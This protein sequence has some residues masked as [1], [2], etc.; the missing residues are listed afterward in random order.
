MKID[1]LTV[2]TG[3]TCR[4]PAVERLLAAR[5]GLTVRSAGTHAEPGAQVSAPMARLL[6]DCGIATE[7]FAARLID[8]F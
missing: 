3:N 2:C 5:T 1:V 4:S 6:H 7:G 8:R